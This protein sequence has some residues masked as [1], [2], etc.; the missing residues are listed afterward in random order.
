MP[1]GEYVEWRKGDRIVLA[2]ETKAKMCSS[3]PVKECTKNSDCK[4][5]EGKCVARQHFA[6]HFHTVES[7]SGGTDIATGPLSSLAQTVYMSRRLC[8]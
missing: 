5:W 6:E 2:Q 8:S 4:V 1:N 3:N 7:E